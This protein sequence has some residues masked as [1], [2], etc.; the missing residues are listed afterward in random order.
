MSEQLS[1]HRLPY[2]SKFL[3]EKIFVKSLNRFSLEWPD[4]FFSVFL[5]GGATKNGKKRSDHY[6]AIDTVSYSVPDEE[7]DLLPA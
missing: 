3:I 2:G 4:R 5:C 6:A 7:I 1:E